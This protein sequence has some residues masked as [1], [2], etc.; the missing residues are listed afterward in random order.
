MNYN[1]DDFYESIT[2]ITDN[3][4]AAFSR[5]GWIGLIFMC[6]CAAIQLW[7]KNGRINVLLSVLGI[8]RTLNKLCVR[9]KYD[10][11]VYREKAITEIMRRHFVEIIEKYADVCIK[12]LTMIRYDD[13]DRQVIPLMMA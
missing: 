6:I 11:L 4:F 13:F 10:R 2:F 1:Y 12:K 7:D 5:S 9:L 8:N 3:I